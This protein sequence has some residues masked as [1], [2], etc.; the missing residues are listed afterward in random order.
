MTI[1]VL[2]MDLVKYNFQQFALDLCDHLYR[3]T[4]KRFLYTLKCTITGLLVQFRIYI[5]NMVKL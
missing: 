3:Q 2:V 5:L 4:L 1:V